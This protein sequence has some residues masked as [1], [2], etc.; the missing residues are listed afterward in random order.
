[1]IRIDVR[2]ERGRILC[3]RSRGHS[4]SQEA[5]KDL[6]CA[7]VSSIVFGTLNALDELAEDS[8]DLEA[9]EDVTITVRQDSGKVQLILQVM[10]KQLET[11]AEKYPKYVKI[12]ERSN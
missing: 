6:I 3:V 8:C 9:G 2:R 11:I 1:M 7:G 4:G 12:T 5:G 10:M